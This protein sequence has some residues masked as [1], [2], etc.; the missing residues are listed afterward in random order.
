VTAKSGTRLFGWAFGLF[1]GGIVASVA[2]FAWAAAI[3]NPRVP[4]W[5]GGIE[6]LVAYATIVLV[7]AAPVQWLATRLL[8]RG[9][10]R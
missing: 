1:A 5:P 9:I 6:I 2:G 10:G 7:V 8:R 3:G 4:F